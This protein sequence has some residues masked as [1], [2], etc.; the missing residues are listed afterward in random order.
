MFKI[1]RDDIQSVLD[2]DPAARNVLEV[3][4]CYP[5][6]H[7]IWAH[8]L[9]HWLWRRGL[10]LFARWISQSMRG[11]TGIEIHPGA[12]IGHNFFIDHGMGVVI[13]ETAE[14]GDNV[15][16][17]HG[18]TLGGTS[19]H[20][21]KRH[22]T[23]GDHVVIGAGAKVLGAITIGAN[24]RIGANAVVVRSAPPDSVIVGVPGQ[25]VVREHPVHTL[26]EKADLEHGSLPDTIGETLA[27]LI[28]HVES[29]EKRVNG[30]GVYGP[31]LHA[32]EHGVW[33]GSD[34]SI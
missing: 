17:Y 16:L 34:F 6:L 9:S 21:V 23:I 33:H 15:T 5:G 18:V 29:L 8:R 1:I 26:T 20:K 12:T 30:G 24:S 4:L 32:P 7:A 28:E 10:K 31:A 27:A 3:L 2:R 11:L 14:V 13:G 22:P 25:V 19:L